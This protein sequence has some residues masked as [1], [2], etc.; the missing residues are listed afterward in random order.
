MYEAA[1]PICERTL[2]DRI[3]EIEDN[4]MEKLEKKRGLQFVFNLSVPGAAIIDADYFI[5][6]CERRY[7]GSGF[8]QRLTTVSLS[9]LAE[10]SKGFMYY[11]LYQLAADYYFR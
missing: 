1:T 8:K 9:L 11:Q 6:K 3:R 4:A 5:R 2:V 10:I 7:G